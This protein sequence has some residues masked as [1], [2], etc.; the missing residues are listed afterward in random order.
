[1]EG[2]HLTFIGI[3]LTGNWLEGLNYCCEEST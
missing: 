2:F 1:M 3:L